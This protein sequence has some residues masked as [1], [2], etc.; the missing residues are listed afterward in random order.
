MVRCSPL[1]STLVIAGALVGCGTEP[2]SPIVRP[3]PIELERPTEVPCAAGATVVL[4]FEISAWQMDNGASE[5]GPGACEGPV[6]FSTRLEHL[7]AGA[8]PSE[9]YDGNWS[10]VS[11]DYNGT[12]P[13]VC[14]APHCGT[15][16]PSD[17][18]VRVNDCTVW[19]Y[20]D[21]DTGLAH[22]VGFSW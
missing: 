12:T 19:G 4:R 5:N 21:A 13:S 6:Q 20:C 3:E 10:Y 15:L 8:M 14:G 1:L 22:A 18:T 2:L 16:L 17:G 11:V 9:G 7:S